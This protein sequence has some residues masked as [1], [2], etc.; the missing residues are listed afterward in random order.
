M[1]AGMGFA[2]AA[3]VPSDSS[4]S[5]KM[6]QAAACREAKWL[7]AILLVGFLVKVA[8]SKLIS[9]Y[10]THACI[11]CTCENSSKSQLFVFILATGPQ[12]RKVSYV[13]LDIVHTVPG[14]GDHL[15]QGKVITLACLCVYI[16]SAHV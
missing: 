7:E 16:V 14:K 2:S 4:C 12:A 9:R 3:P 10:G 5:L 15:S 6:L 1:L 13:C 8:C 11:P